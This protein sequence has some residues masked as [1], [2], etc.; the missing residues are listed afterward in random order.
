MARLAQVVGPGL[1]HHIT[2]QGNRRHGNGNEC[3]V[4]RILAP[5]RCAPGLRPTA[6]GGVRLSRRSVRFPSPPRCATCLDSDNRAC[7]RIT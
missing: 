6:A 5:L 7:L 2:Q 3:G 4:P 1:P